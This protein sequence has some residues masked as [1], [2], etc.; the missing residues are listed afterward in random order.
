MIQFSVA[1]IPQQQGSMRA[2]VNKKTGR[3]SVTGA[4][5]NTQDWRQRIATEAQRAVGE[6][7]PLQVPV[8]V[9]AAFHLKRPLTRAK[10]YIYPDRKP[11]V[12]NPGIRNL[13]AGSVCP[14]FM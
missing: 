13:P 10:K 11:D 6:A 3:A 8:S 14:C 1:G 7:G 2:F 9:A 5:R 12:D 4:N